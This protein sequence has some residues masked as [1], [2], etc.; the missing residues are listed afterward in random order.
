MATNVDSYAKMRKLCPSPLP[1]Y[2]IIVRMNED[3][4][5]EYREYVAVRANETGDIQNKW[6][7]AHEYLQNEYAHDKRKFE[8]DYLRD[9]IIPQWRAFAPLPLTSQGRGRMLIT[10]EL[11]EYK[12][13]VH[14]RGDEGGVWQEE[15]HMLQLPGVIR[16]Y[17]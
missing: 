5:N 12:E 14:V 17:N 15:Y 11:E 6:Q 16:R 8:D 4:V 7:A 13:Y 9:S 3:E 10:M 2:T 1:P